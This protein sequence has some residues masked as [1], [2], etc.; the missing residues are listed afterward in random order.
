MIQGVK[1]RVT[2]NIK[3]NDSESYTFKPVKLVIILLCLGVFFYVYTN[4]Q[5]LLEKLDNRPIN[6]FILTNNPSYTTYDDVRDSVL[7]MGGLK[8]FFGQDIDA[9]REQIETMPWIKKAAVRKIWPDKLSIAVIEHQPIAIWNEGEFLSKEGEIFQLP[10]D[11]LEDKNLPHLSGPDYQST[12]VLEA[13]HQV[14]ANLTEK[15]LKLKAVTIDDRGAWQIVLDNNLVLKLGRGEWKAKLD[16]FV[17]IYPQIEVP[18][19][20][21]LSYV[22]LRYS[23]GAAVGFADIDAN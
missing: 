13:W 18:E 8:G 5:S 11:K 23:V 2:Q 12:K 14:N 4:W 7:K 22:D 10:M 19:N 15:G 6:A 3:Y 1:R 16:R 20:K 17:T 21:K 9:V